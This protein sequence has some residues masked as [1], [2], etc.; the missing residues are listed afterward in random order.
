MMRFAVG[1]I[2]TLSATSGTGN[3]SRLW[4]PPAQ[5]NCLL[6]AAF[7]CFDSSGNPV[8]IHN[9][10]SWL[11]FG[12]A[13]ASAATSVA[14]IPIAWDR[15]GVAELDAY[16]YAGLEGDGE[17]LRQSETDPNNPMALF[18]FAA[19]SEVPSGG[20]ATIRVQWG[21]HPRWGAG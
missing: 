8:A 6:Y 1:T 10:L 2:K 18:A 3:V 19:G 12:I 11:D 9:E 20:R 17:P 16:Y 14:R 7:M 5:A 13:K 4:T 15:G 21:C